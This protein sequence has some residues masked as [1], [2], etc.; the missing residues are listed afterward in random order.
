MEDL[1]E[2]DAL[3]ALNDD[4]VREGFCKVINHK[5]QY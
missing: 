1:A 2:R 3:N 5:G 4:D